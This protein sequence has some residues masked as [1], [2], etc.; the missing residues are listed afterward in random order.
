MLKLLTDIYPPDIKPV[1]D[2]LYLAMP[3]WYLTGEEGDIYEAL[4]LW[5][6]RD[7]RWR[8]SDGTAWDGEMVWRGLAFDP[9]EAAKASRWVPTDDADGWVSGV[10]VLGATCDD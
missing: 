2:G 7:G 4:S 8:H 5:A 3:A 9:A 1:R 10:F 6:F